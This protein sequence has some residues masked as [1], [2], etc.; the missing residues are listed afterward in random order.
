MTVCCL[1]LTIACFATLGLSQCFGPHREETHSRIFKEPSPKMFTGC[2][3]L[4]HQRM[5][6]ALPEDNAFQQSFLTLLADGTYTGDK[7]PVFVKMPHEGFK[8]QDL[9]HY[10]GKWR[11]VQPGTAY[12][13]DAG[14]RQDYWSF[15]LD[16]VPGGPRRADGFEDLI[17]TSTISKNT[18]LVEYI[19][20]YTGD[21][22]SGDVLT[23][24]R[25]ASTNEDSSK[26]NR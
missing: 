13:Q 19:S 24:K 22:D 1:R 7:Y 17:V 18:G 10:R 15:A 11:I 9:A 20:L 4:V 6:R 14:A 8:L 16:P 12:N 2:Y 21:M 26:T 25:V 23:Y 3:R 5:D